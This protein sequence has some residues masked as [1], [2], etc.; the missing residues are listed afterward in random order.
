LKIL[1]GDFNAKLGREDIIKQAIGN[2]SLHQDSN[3][4]GVTTV[5]VA[6]YINLAVKSMMFPHRNIHKHTSSILMGRLTT[7]LI[8][9]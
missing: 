3:G 6:T 7:R 8:T 9:Y 2:D 1:L 4:N 5:N